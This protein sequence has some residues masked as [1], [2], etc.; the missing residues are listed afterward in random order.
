M[1]LF[2]DCPGLDGVAAEAA[3]T[4]TGKYP[5]DSFVSFEK[6]DNAESFSG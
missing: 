3:I 4:F 2:N 1:Y 5:T 6:L